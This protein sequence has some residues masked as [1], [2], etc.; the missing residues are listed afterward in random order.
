MHRHVSSWEHYSS[1]ESI[2]PLHGHRGGHASCL[3]RVL[4]PFPRLPL[5]TVSGWQS[6]YDV[7]VISG[8]PLPVGSRSW[9][10]LVSDRH[11]REDASRTVDTWAE[12]FTVF[13]CPMF[14][15]EPPVHGARSCVRVV[16]GKQSR[17]WWQNLDER[18]HDDELHLH[19]HFLLIITT[20]ES[21]AATQGR[22]NVSV[23]ESH[24]ALTQ[25]HSSW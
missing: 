16:V 3:K 2:F 8:I 11:R 17:F 12:K 6:R 23:N 21:C 20:S 4:P 24:P 5:S 22:L 18:Q 10:S 15:S 19:L 7:R 14:S 9:V 25:P 13:P 1:D